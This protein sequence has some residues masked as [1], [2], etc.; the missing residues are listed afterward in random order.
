MSLIFNVSVSAFLKPSSKELKE[1]KCIKLDHCM[2]RILINN[3][4]NGVENSVENSVD[5]SV[6]KAYPIEAAHNIGAIIMKNS[7]ENKDA[8][9][10]LAGNKKI[11]NNNIN[12]NRTQEIKTIGSKAGCFSRTD[13]REIETWGDSKHIRIL[14]DV[15]NF[16]DKVLEKLKL[17]NACTT[18][19]FIITQKHY[20]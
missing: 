20:F 19:P 7:I 17:H 9:D 13:Q 11:G 8:A 4:F 15:P 6:D 14:H 18:L 12:D 2:K 3:L 10:F 16:V 5:N 1:L